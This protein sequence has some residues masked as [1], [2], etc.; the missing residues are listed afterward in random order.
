[1]E[2]FAW[3]IVVLILGIVVVLAFK[4]ELGGFISRAQKISKDGIETTPQQSQQ[5]ISSESDAEELMRSFDSV[6]LR[7]QEDLIRKTLTDKI[8]DNNVEQIKVLIR[9]LAAMQMA[10]AF[11]KLY[12]NIYGSQIGILQHLNLIPEG[13]PQDDIKPFYELAKK[14]NPEAYE[15][16][17][18]D[19]YLDFLI[20]Q[21]LV[22]QHGDRYLITNLGVDFL[23][24]LIRAR[25]TPFKAL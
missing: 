10:F 11:E 15:E 1:M 16:Y 9:H 2:S 20:S 23:G 18:F 6:V 17:P 14:E 7:E 22:I 19:R 5:N 13:V 4:K 21:T 3:P 8:P 12:I 24:Y 25:L